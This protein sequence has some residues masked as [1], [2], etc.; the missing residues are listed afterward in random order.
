MKYE[1]EKQ[2]LILQKLPLNTLI[3]LKIPQE[4]SEYL[5]VSDE[6]YFYL[7]NRIWD[8]E[9]LTDG[10]EKPLY[11]L[12]LLVF[13]AISATKIYGPYYFSTSV[14]QHNYLEM[15]KVWFWPK[16]LHTSEYNKY[17][18]QQDGPLL[19]HLILFKS[20]WPR[21]LVKYFLLQK[22]QPIHIFKTLSLY[23]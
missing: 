22:K 12:K 19:I 13:C 15:L 8:I 21:N 3:Y 20:G 16:H 17:Y 18:F 6:A 4:K 10:I 23:D 14:N 2:A 7:T 9:R 1:I 11:F 5:I